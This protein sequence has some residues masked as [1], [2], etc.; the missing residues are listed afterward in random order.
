MT[1]DVG[2][3]RRHRRHRQRRTALVYLAAG[4]CYLAVSVGLWWH[5][6]T[7]HPTTTFTCGCGD[8]ALFLWFLAWPAYAIAHGQ[9]LFYSTALFHP[10]GIN[11]LSNT[12]VLAIGVPLA[13]VTWLFGPVAT[14]NVASTL[15]P[16]LTGLATFW[17]LRRWV[18]WSPAAF[19]GGLVYGFS[20][21]VLSSLQFGHLMTAALMIFPLVVGCLDELLVRQRHR[22]VRVGV[23]LG[24]LVVVEFFVSTEMT[25]IMAMSMVLG[26]VLLVAYR[27]VSDRADLVRRSRTALPGVVAALVVAG[28]LL[29]YPAWFALAGPAHLSGSL[30]PD[31]P[32]VGGY[33]LRSF[34]DASFGTGHS[35]LSQLGGYFGTTLPSSAYVGWGMLAVLG[36][37]IVVWRRDRRLWLFGALALVT[38]S[39]T[40]GIRP[41]QWVPWNEIGQLP[42]VSN[43]IEQRFVAVTYLALVVMLALV[44]D[45]LRHLRLPGHSR[46]ARWTAG[47]RQ[48]VPTAVAVVA[49]GVA[50][51]PILGATASAMPFATRP[52]DVPAWFVERA[53][54]LPPGQVLLAYPAPFSGIQSSMAWQAIDRMHFAQAG[55]GGP[56]GTAAR[57]GKERPGFAVLASLG[58]G[59]T[60]PPTGTPAE[61]AAVR[62]ALRGWGVTM[63][64]IPDQPGLPAVLRGHDPQYAAGL[65]TAVLGRKPIFQDGA[66]V[67][68]AVRHTR[69]VLHLPAGTLARCADGAPP[70]AVSPLAV[71]R[72]VLAAGGIR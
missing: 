56:Q 34:V 58:F 15:T 44:A 17:L 20:P 37:A 35:L 71:P 31:L 32:V 12:S 54:Y 41:H 64:V 7:S 19:V 27:A 29:A 65:M 1:V 30:W 69:S 9:S 24:L 59:F 61:L 43:V 3:H 26:L 62:Q 2:Q 68:S 57:A 36:I 6:W 67:W 14:L 10:A 33:T 22:P 25:V 18:R 51:V 46:G 50:L 28:V 60:A 38:A 16:V 4:A 45:R 42:I 72:C 5:V 23:V 55:G 47:A 40:L 11:L 8:P 70:A 13:P 49:L 66:W 48:V 63:V 39:L 21:F 53:P 52:V